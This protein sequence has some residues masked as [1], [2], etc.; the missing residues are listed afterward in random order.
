ML[1]LTL[2]DGYIQ[3]FVILPVD[4]PTC[5]SHDGHVTSTENG[6]TKT[7]STACSLV[8]QIKIGEAGAMKLPYA[9]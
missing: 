7:K 9:F 5:Q 3:K 4:A 2:F 6:D 8:L 1:A